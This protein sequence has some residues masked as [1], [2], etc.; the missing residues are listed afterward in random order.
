MLTDPDA[1]IWPPT[2]VNKE[3]YVE[4]RLLGPLAS[5]ILRN[6]R[7]NGSGVRYYFNRASLSSLRD[8]PEK[9]AGIPSRLLTLRHPN[10][11]VPAERQQRKQVQAIIV[12]AA[13][14]RSNRGV[15]EQLDA[16]LSLGT[17]GR[18]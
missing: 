6:Q 5:E 12:I 17:F 18:K 8:P 7:N 13:L 1:L 2:V 3:E 15:P 9:F 4:L 11:V 14:P 16:R 10:P